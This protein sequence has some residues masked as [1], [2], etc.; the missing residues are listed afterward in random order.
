MVKKLQQLKEAR[1][2][3]RVASGIAAFA[4]M[5]GTPLAY[6]VPKVFALD[7]CT[8]AVYETSTPSG[9]QTFT[10][11]TDAV[12]VGVKF[13]VARPMKV[14]AI[15]FYRTVAND[16]GYTVRLFD[17][18][19]NLLSSGNVI[20]G[21]SGVPTWQ[22]VSLSS[23]VN[24][25]AD[26]TYVAAYYTS[27]GEYYASSNAYASA[28][29]DGLVST[30]SG[31]GVYKYGTN[32]SQFPDQTY[33]NTSYYVS[34]VLGYEDTTAPS[35]PSNV[36]AHPTLNRGELSWTASTDT[37]GLYSNNG[38]T[39]DVD[40]D[41]NTTNVPSNKWEQYQLTPGSHSYSVKAV[42]HCGNQS[43]AATGTFNI[44]DT[45]V[46]GFGA[47]TSGAENDDHDAVTVGA[48]FSTSSAGVIKGIRFYRSVAPTLP[49][50]VGFWT[51][52]GTLVATASASEGI[53]SDLNWYNINF[54]SPVS[55][56][57]NTT[58]VVGYYTS[59]GQYNAT[60]D[61]FSSSVSNGGI[62]IPAS[63]GVYTYG[64]GLQF[65]TSTYNDT[66]YWVDVVFDAN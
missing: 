10:N 25:S 44:T 64:T 35:A 43:T 62:T 6:S 23:P 38:M 65:P 26:T 14:T 13:S 24:I 16:A 29:T 51:E 18:S 3:R 42:D 27:N 40:V 37:S 59:T 21:Q 12:T 17:N 1:F 48:K 55:V 9:G 28:K 58:Y 8:E 66:N 39:Y 15:K 60:E 30:P 36:S 47:A 56:S 22:S 46:F 57:A 11:D 41:N 19:G 54:S 2:T 32:S 52:D 49:V 50:S 7:N 61:G 20:E 5:L 31:A 4:L 33:G 45:S 34:P 63:G 53:S